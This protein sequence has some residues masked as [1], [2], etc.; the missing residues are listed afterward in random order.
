MEP[1][2]RYRLHFSKTTAM[3]FT[4]H[5]DLQRT[6]ERTLR[7]SESP[8]SHSRGFTHRTRIQFALALPLGI[9][10]DCELADIWL[11]QD[12]PAAEIVARLQAAAP[13][14]LC[15]QQA[16][17][18]AE[19][20]AS[21]PTRVHSAEYVVTLLEDVPRLAE[22]VDRVLTAPAWIQQR[23]TKTYDLRPLILSLIELPPDPSG[24]RRLGMSLLSQPSATGRPDEVLIALGIDPHTARYHRTALHLLDD[25]RSF[26]PA[27]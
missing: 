6:F 26:T 9:T 22:A 3:R 13:P 2:V 19:P 8:V 11:D 14:G 15:I 27:S 17:A 21:L 24:D 4:G 16:Q 18:V 10:S 20:A 7:R 23:G 12:L 25:P 5:L 1:S